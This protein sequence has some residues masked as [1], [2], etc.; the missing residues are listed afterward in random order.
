MPSTV[1][2]CTYQSAR[3]AVKEPDLMVVASKQPVRIHAELLLMQQ[4]V[5]GLTDG[6]WLL[7][8]EQVRPTCVVITPVGVVAAACG[9]FDLP[10]WCSSCTGWRQMCSV[11]AIHS[12]YN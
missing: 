3:F 1:T 2:R 4:Y 11:T 7:S 6:C 8:V 9:T 10:A 12:L 5:Q